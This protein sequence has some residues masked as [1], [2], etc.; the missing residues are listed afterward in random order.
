MNLL[1]LFPQLHFEYLIASTLWSLE[2]LFFENF[3][4]LNRSWDLF[5]KQRAFLLFHR[6]LC[7]FEPI[8]TKN[9]VISS[10]L[11]TGSSSK[12][13][14][15]MAKKILKTQFSVF[16]HLGHSEETFDH[17]LG[18]FFENCASSLDSLSRVFPSFF[19]RKFFNLK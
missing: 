2:I 8:P 18:T 11:P 15:K 6:I 10:I 3:R 12:I 4:A 19:Q 17:K 9:A 1:P 5:V 13:V 7:V 14:I 16:E